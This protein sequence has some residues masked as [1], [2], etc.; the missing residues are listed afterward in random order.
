MNDALCVREEHVDGLYPKG[1]QWYWR[2]DFVKT[3][4]RAAI[5][6][7]LEQAGK[8]L[9]ELSLMHLYPIDGAVH[10]VGSGETAW[11]C[12]MRPGR[13][14]LPASIQTPEGGADHALDQG[15]LGCG[16]PVRS[17]GAP[18]RTS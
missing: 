16:A 4:P 5:D 12:R 10:R 7:H 3:L 18:T 13:W 2:G 11:S 1:M 14:S 17:P 9:S 6:V 8:T 15:L